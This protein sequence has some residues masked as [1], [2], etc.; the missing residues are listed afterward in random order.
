M[1][2]LTKKVR[3]ISKITVKVVCGKEERVVYMF[4]PAAFGTTGKGYPLEKFEDVISEVE[5][6]TNEE[7]LFNF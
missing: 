7:P 4:N 5:T 6:E 3:R 1:G 2:L